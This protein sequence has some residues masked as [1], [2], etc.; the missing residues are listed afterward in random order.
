MSDTTTAISGIHTIVIP[1]TDHERAISFYTETLGFE[2]RRDASYGAGN[3]WVEVAA[4]GAQTTIALANRRDG[5]IV[6]EETGIRLATGDANAAHEDL[7]ARG[8]EVDDI[9]NFGPSVP[10]MFYMRDP[11]GNRLVVVDVA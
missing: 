2:V 6:G 5:Q 4:P 3:R 10:P 9:L 11:E 7:K 8:V 1:V